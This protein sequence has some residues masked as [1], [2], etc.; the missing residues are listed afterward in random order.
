VKNGIPIGLAMTCDALIFVEQRAKHLLETFTG[1]VS[2]KRDTPKFL[3][4]QHRHLRLA[5]PAP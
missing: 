4:I 3:F 1:P 5:P 2:Q